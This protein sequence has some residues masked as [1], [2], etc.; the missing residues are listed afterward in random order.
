MFFPDPKDPKNLP[1][2]PLLIYNATWPAEECP[3]EDT[4]KHNTFCDKIVSTGWSS[5]ITYLIFAQFSKFTTTLTDP[6]LNTK[7]RERGETIG[8]GICR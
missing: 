6:S 3:E 2:S 5:K 1:I 7:W 4:E 8:D